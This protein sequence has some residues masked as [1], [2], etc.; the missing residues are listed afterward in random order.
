MTRASCPAAERLLIVK[1]VCGVN[2]QRICR[3][4]F[5][6]C[7]NPS[8][9][10]VIIL[11]TNLKEIQLSVRQYQRRCR[12]QTNSKKRWKWKCV[13]EVVQDSP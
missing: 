12:T 11:R 3:Q 6:V 13:E 1:T 8:G 2:V 7:D 10:R 5:R 9:N 4:G